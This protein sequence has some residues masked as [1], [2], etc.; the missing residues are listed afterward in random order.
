MNVKLTENN[1]KVNVKRPHNRFEDS[2]TS[3]SSISLSISVSE[4]FAP[5]DTVV[6]D[7]NL[8]SSY[9]F[10]T[11]ELSL[12]QEHIKKDIQK[13]LNHDN[14]DELLNLSVCCIY[15]ECWLRKTQSK[16]THKYLIFI[17]QL[18]LK[19]ITKQIDNFQYKGY[20]D[21][22]SSSYYIKYLNQ[23][24]NIFFNDFDD[25]KTVFINQFYL[26]ILKICQ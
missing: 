10:D 22:V 13:L 25:I 23:Q 12:L 1:Y 21:H 14:D 3:V 4:D 2:D 5:A 19:L 15:S 6:K 8:E 16:K 9:L 20:C 7:I 11:K 18:L 24:W 26:N 17:L